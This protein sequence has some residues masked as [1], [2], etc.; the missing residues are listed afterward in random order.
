MRWLTFMARRFVAGETEEEAVAAV[1]VLNSKGVSATLDIL[2][3]NVRD[4]SQAG[5]Y[6]AGYVN[7]L[8][9]IKSS[10]VD[11][12]VSLKL[13]M[14]GLDIDDSLCRE[15][16]V[17]V[18]SKAAEL[19]NFVRV[20]MEGSAYTQRTLDIFKDVYGEFGG[21]HVGIVLQAYLHRTERD[22]RD[23]MDI[24]APVRLCKGAYKEPASVAIQDKAEVNANYERLMYMG[25]E[26][27]AGLAVATH[28]ENLVRKA[29]EFASSKGL[30]PASF[31]FQMLYGIRRKRLPELASMGYRARAY[32]PFGTDWFPYFYRRL[33]ERK[34][35]VLFVIKN[36]FRD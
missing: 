26:A 17:K 23:M 18:V 22:M 7:L 13:T 31:E 32:V 36:L 25:L 15:N 8:N 24:G 3:E 28:D 6:A 34:E 30:D 21:A 10:G 16:L 2:G 27:G 19:G 9:T 33:R 35:N 20:D 29:V 4:H 12:G 11:S 14:L 5:E 1:R